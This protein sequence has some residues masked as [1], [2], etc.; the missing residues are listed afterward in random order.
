MTRLNSLS[1][2]L[3]AY[4]NLITY[5]RSCSPMSLAGERS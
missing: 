3:Q 4:R 5:L 1:R 2:F